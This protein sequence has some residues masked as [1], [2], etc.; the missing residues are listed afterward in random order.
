MVHAIRDSTGLPLVVTP[1]AE[2]A[3]LDAGV[4]FDLDLEN[5][6]SVE[7]L[8]NLITRTAGEEVVWTIRHEAVLVTTRAKAAG[9]FVFELHDIRTL[10][11]ARTDFIAPR[12]D[13][14][15][16]LDDLEDDDG[17]GPFGGLGEQSRRFEEEDVATLV[18]ENVAPE[19]WDA[20]GIS[21]EA[22]NG[23]LLVVH[24]REVQRRIARLLA[25]LGA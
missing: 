24:T 5:P 2:D 19:S 13:R 6:I 11:M 21:I 14:I 8:L 9:R 17:G 1:A 7:N 3:V 4:V 23:F 22:A 25:A 18:Q 12:I 15:R 20:D 16:L 10:T